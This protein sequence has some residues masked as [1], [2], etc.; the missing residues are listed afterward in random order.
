M[1][2]PTMRPICGDDEDCADCYGR[3]C[4]RDPNETAA[5]YCCGNPEDHEHGAVS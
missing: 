3:Y 1:T 2:D 5:A 4:R